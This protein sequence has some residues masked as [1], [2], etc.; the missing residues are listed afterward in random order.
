MENNMEISQ[1]HQQDLVSWVP[2][3]PVCAGE[4]ADCRS[5]TAS[6]TGRSNTASGTGYVLDSRHLGTFPARGE[7]T[8]WEGSD[9]QSRWGSHLVSWVPRRP[10]CAG[11]HS[12]YRGNPSSGTGPLLGLHLQP[13]GRSKRQTS[14][15][16]PCKR[17]AC[18]KRVLWPLKLRRELDS[19]DSWPRLTESQ[20]EQNPA[21]DNYNN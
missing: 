5:N 3:R 8:T 14:V 13:G 9:L 2:L 4:S 15:H 18:L 16:L 11:E 17:R 21:R 6:G 1:N 10:V 19:Q 12:D 20:K 7:V